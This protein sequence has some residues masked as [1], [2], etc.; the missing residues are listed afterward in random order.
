[1]PPLVLDNSPLAKRVA[2]LKYLIHVLLSDVRE[3]GVN[4]QDFFSLG[5]N[6]GLNVGNFLV[7]PHERQ[8]FE[9]SAESHSLLLPF[10]GNLFPAFV[11]GDAVHF[12]LN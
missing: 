5:L 3:F 1:M 4:V 6:L 12:A 11:F 7:C 2:P 8:N 10:K 9:K